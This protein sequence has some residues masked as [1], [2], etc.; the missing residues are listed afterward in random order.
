[1]NIT[2]ENIMINQKYN[3][4]RKISGDA[5]LGIYYFYYFNSL[6]SFNITVK[7]QIFTM[8]VVYFN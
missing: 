2:L 4:V 7:F 3:E 6:C 8:S 5:T 1:M